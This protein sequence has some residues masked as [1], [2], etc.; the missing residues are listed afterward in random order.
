M[1]VPIGGSEKRG[2]IAAPPQ[3]GDLRTK[4]KIMD[5]LAQPH[6]VRTGP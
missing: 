4:I 6:C 3:E 2:G 1:H 5:E